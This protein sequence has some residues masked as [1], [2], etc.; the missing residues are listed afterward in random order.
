MGE[1]AVDYLLKEAAEHY[2]AGRPDRAEVLCGEILTADPD[3]LAA[4]HLSAIIA[5]VTDRAAEGAKLLSRVFVIAPDH[6]PA[7]A[8]LGDA[9]TVKG[10]RE[11]AVDAFS[12]AVARQPRDASLHGK[13]GAA[14]CNLSRFEEAE[15]AYRHAIALDPDSARSR[16]NLAVALT[17]QGLMADG[18]AVYREVIA[19]DPVYPDVWLNLGTALADQNKLDEAIV[20]YRQALTTDPDNSALH[21]SLGG[22]LYRHRQLDEAVIQF[23]RATAL[24]PDNLAAFRLLGLALHDLGRVDEAAQVYRQVSARAPSDVDSVASLGA[25]LCA[26]GELDAAMAACDL[27]LAIDPD[28]APAH[29]NIGILFDRKNDFDAAVAAHRRAIAAS[30]GYAKGHANLVVALLNAGKVEEA[31][32]A[33]NRAIALDPER[34]QTRFN[35]SHALLMCG[36]L[37]NGFVEHQ[38]GRKCAGAGAGF[39]DLPGSEWQGEALAGRTLLL[40]AEFGIGDAL[41]FVRYLPMVAAR[42]RSERSSI[43]LQVQPAIAP[44]LRTMPGVTVVSRDD[45]LPPFDVHLPLMDLPRIFRTTLDSIPADIP[46]LHADPVKLAQWRSAVDKTSSLKVG[47]VW[48]GTALHKS[49][50]Y[51]SLPAKNVL[52]RLV[53]PGVQL[54]S[55]QKEVR[56]EDVPVL[57]GLS[58]E[59]IDLAPTLG[60]FA[61]TAAAVGAL[62]LVI[63]VDTST[64][65][66]AGALGCPVWVLLPHSLDWRWL[67]EREDS[68]W[69]PTM[70]LFRQHRMMAWDGVISRVSAELTRVVAG[71]RDLIWPPAMRAD[72][73]GAAGRDGSQS[74]QLAPR[75]PAAA[76]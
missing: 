16:F 40:Y 64:A 25:C 27:A 14:L 21:A 28:H 2:G 15:A 34:P 39:P 9:L 37:L 3:H 8:T 55:L 65:H 59:V 26:L 11:G 63:S 29:T 5:F 69:Y 76:R 67:H 1:A 75:I 22:V 18:E 47:V 31:L 48:A 10:E 49:D 52:P 12:R 62:D 70:R 4:L 71:E 74:P 38:W 60:S 56:L 30:P 45:P 23:R 66:L 44:L 41:Q 35:H 24:D 20:A 53:M 72:S 73:T 7:L 13:L 57:D 19:R 36:D 51:R 17:G 50:R 6:A 54:F 42:E 68:P 58:S 43:V 32:D 61:D 46:Y 33:S